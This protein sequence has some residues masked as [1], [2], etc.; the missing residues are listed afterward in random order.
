MGKDHELLEAARNG[1]I[2]IVEKILS[3]RAKRSGPLASLRRGPG[4]NVQDSSGY[5][6]LHHAAL[7]GHREVVQ[8]LLGHEA[9]TNIADGKGST[10]LH[11]AAW[12]GNEDIVRLLL[13]HGPSVPNVNLKTKDSETALHCAAQ[14]GHTAV[15]AHLLEHSCDPTIRNSREETALDLAA[16]YGRLE[17]VELLVRA[18]PE[19]LHPFSRSNSSTGVF[20]HTPLHLASRNG[21][22]AVVDVLLSAGMDVNART[23]AGTALHEAALCG[24]TDCVR[25]LLESGVDLSARDSGGHTVLDVLGQFPTHVTHDIMEIIQGYRDRPRSPP[26]GG[27]RPAADGGEGGGGRGTWRKGGGEHHR[28]REH[29]HQQ[30]QQRHQE[31]GDAEDKENADPLPPI[32]TLGSP[33]ENVRLTP[34]GGREEEEE[35]AGVEGEEEEEDDEEELDVP[36]VDAEDSSPAHSPSSSR[37]RYYD[38]GGGGRHRRQ[39]PQGGRQRRGARDQPPDGDGRTSAAS[40]AS[41]GSEGLASRSQPLSLPHSHHHVHQAHHSLSKSLDSS[42]VSEDLSDLLSRDADR[43]SIS[44]GS[45]VPPPSPLARGPSD[46]AEGPRPHRRCSHDAYVPMAP[47]LKVSPT[48]PKKPPRRNL[49]VSPTHPQLGECGGVAYE[50]LFLARSGGG[51]GKGDDASSSGG[52]LTPHDLPRPPPPSSAHSPGREAAALRRGRSA[53]QYVEMR[54]GCCPAPPHHHPPPVPRPPHHEHHD[55]S[56]R[57]RPYCRRKLRRHNDHAY[58]N[59]EPPAGAWRGG[60]GK[61]Y[62]E[63]EVVAGSWGAVAEEAAVRGKKAKKKK[64]KTRAGMVG[65]SAVPLSPTHYQ[66]P[67]TPDHPPPSAL[68]AECSILERIRPLSQEYKRRSRDMETETED[69]LLCGAA[70]GAPS[71]DASSGSLSSSVSLSDRSLSTDNNVEEFLGD[72][73][74]AG[75]FKGSTAGDGPPGGVG[76]RSLERPKTLRKLKNVY[77]GGGFVGSGAAADCGDGPVGDAEDEDGTGRGSLSILSPFDEQEEWNKISE[78]MASFGTGLVRESVFV[79]ELEKEFQSRL[80]L[81]RSESRASATAASTAPPVAPPSPTAP[82]PTSI[83]QWLESIGL[84][85]Y[86][87]MFVFHGYDDVDFINGVLEECDLRTMGVVDDGHA[88]LLWLS[89]SRLPRSLPLFAAE[90]RPPPA[91]LEH[92]LRALRLENAYADTFRKN[93]LTDVERIVRIWEAELT[94]VLEIDKLGHRRRLLASVGGGG[95]VSPML[96]AAPPGLPGER[97]SSFSTPAKETAAS[98][99]AAAAS[100]PAA[101]STGTLR[102]RNKKNRPAPPPPPTAPPPPQ[103]TPAPPPKEATTNGPEDLSIRDPAELLVGVPATLTTQWRHRPKVLLA[104]SVTYLASY[105]GSTLVRELRGTESTKKSIQKL[106]RSSRD[107]RVRPEILLSISYSGV[108]FLNSATKDV[109][110]EHEIRNIHCACQ[111]ADDLTHFA[112]IT[113]D[114][115]SRDHYCHVFCVDTMEQ[116]TE[117]ILTLGQAFEVA[118]QMALREQ[119]PCP[120]VARGHTR[121]QSANQIV[122]RNSPAAAPVGGATLVPVTSNGS[123]GATHARSRSV[124]EIEVNGGGVAR[125][126]TTPTGCGKGVGPASPLCQAP[127]VFTEEM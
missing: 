65:P 42:C 25:A 44:S 102:H 122:Q 61:R 54:G 33:Y 40:T 119:F 53:D 98:S 3:Q 37:W 43:V 63:G 73:P 18:H 115:Q 92:W 35:G 1:N 60:D 109:V 116:A 85:E 52:G 90:G 17:T 48:P 50:Y 4:A 59:Y 80:G 87:K 6:A 111:D 66:Q 13:C 11:L 5:S 114:H 74:F 41:A 39:R 62:S 84:P 28:R 121:S 78:I 15:V 89:V 29:H 46:P 49:S 71:L 57:Q 47:G 77:D 88:A 123:N 97:T 100:T 27:P 126:P 51:H 30:Q 21:H 32:P 93:M 125:T 45:S 68:Q 117:I 106:K 38:D 103:T 58:E 8:L 7:N 26:Q 107:G 19:L 22:R 91:S 75:L 124:N 79:E 101:P 120:G 104:G 70:A 94:T 86:E 69:G 20:P 82:V 118:Y 34:K 2:P 24:K 110:C 113:K 112:Y 81:S 96:A 12:T 83:G 108:K 55:P 127:V 64:K 76:G 99:P 16:Q 67:P 56:E 10:P 105:L 95:V 72:A 14:Y 36:V 9:S 31:G 23:A